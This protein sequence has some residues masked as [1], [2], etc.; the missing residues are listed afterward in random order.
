MTP[1]DP[2]RIVA[3]KRDG[4]TLAPAEVRAF[5]E[6]YARGDVARPAR[7]RVPDGGCIR[8][9]DDG[10]TLALTTAMVDSGETVDFTGL[11][12]PTVDKHSTGGVADGV[13][14]VFAPLGAALG[15]RRWPSSRAAGW[16]TR[17]GR[18]T[19]SSRS[20]ACGPTCRP[21]SSRAQVERIGC[22]VAAQSADLVPADGRALRAPRRHRHGRL[23]PADRGERDV[24]EARRRHRPDP[25]RRE[26]GVRRVHEDA[27]GR[28]SELADG[29]PRPRRAVGGGRAS[30]HVTDMSQPLGRRRRQRARRRGGGA[31]AARRRP[32]TAAGPDGAARRRRAGADAGGIGRDEA[33]ARGRA[34]PGRRERAGAVPGAWS[35]PRAATRA[36]STIPR[37]CCRGPR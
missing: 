6:G 18:S 12:V 37:P 21:T 4:E 9:L 24:E 7:R 14:L 19:S 2:R 27:R 35:R 20:P 10:E 22:A 15:P 3:A 1:T 8:G 16:A 31:A 26:G 23:D 30:P 32:R 29:V 28:A 13:T 17:A 5:V 11:D 25:A 36:S 34:R 33:V